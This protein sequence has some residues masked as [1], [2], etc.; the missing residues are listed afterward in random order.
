MSINLIPATFGSR[1]LAIVYDI[2]IALFFAF[3]ATLIIQQIIIQLE[4]VTLE[5]IKISVEET[6]PTIPADSPINIL[7]RNLWLIV[8]FLYF[9]YFWTKSGQTPGMK[10]WN[11]KLIN[12]FGLNITWMQAFIR[13]LSAGFGFS[14]LWILFDKNK[15]ALHDHLSRSKLIKTIASDS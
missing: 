1:I 10:V 4:L 15:L 14:L 2:L 12:Q 6:I 13:F 7:L 11:I 3:I 5:H 9:G 8:P